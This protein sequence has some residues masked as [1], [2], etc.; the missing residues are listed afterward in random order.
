MSLEGVGGHGHARHGAHTT[1][2]QQETRIQTKIA[3]DGAKA[4]TPRATTFDSNQ[5]E[6]EAVRRA[7]TVFNKNNAANPYPTTITT[8]KGKVK[9]NTGP[10]VVGGRKG[11]Y[12]SGVEVIRDANGKPL[13]GRPVQ[14]TGQDPSAK[15]IFRYDPNTGQWDK[16]TQYPT[17]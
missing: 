9:P 4:P 16:V 8:P 12:G 13:P 1:L 17:N 2:T 10:I 14:P 11:G 3:P 7:E 15:V 6:L 5:A